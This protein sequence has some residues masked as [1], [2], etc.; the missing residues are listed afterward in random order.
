LALSST[1]YITIDVPLR[2]IAVGDKTSIY[3]NVARTEFAA[4]VESGTTIIDLDKLYGASTYELSSLIISLSSP[5]SVEL[6]E[7]Y[8]YKEAEWR[9]ESIKD[10]RDEYMQISAVRVRGDRASRRRAYG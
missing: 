6:K 2:D 3:K 8:L 10:Y 9:I 4:A 7:I 5:A 1:D